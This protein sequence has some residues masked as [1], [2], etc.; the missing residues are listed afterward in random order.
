MAK[1]KKTK[2]SKQKFPTLIPK[3]NSRVRQEYLDY[4]YIDELSEEEKQYLDDFNKEWYCAS[5]GKQAD[6]GKNNRFTKGKAAVKE[7]TDE[8]NRRNNDLYGNVRNK[9][10][11]TK[12]LNYNENLNMVEDQLS[13]DVNPSNME[14]ALIEF[15]DDAKNLKNS[16]DD[17]G[18]DS[19]NT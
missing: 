16:T 3:Y 7:R 5:V 19:D 9:V 10:G 2:R 11:A 14:D 4:D 6:E 8:N 18:E 13:R 12:I 17:S 15:L 1:K